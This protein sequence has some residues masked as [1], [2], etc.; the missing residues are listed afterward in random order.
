MPCAA[1]CSPYSARGRFES[2]PCI[3]KVQSAPKRPATGSRKRSVEPLS[4][5][6]SS[7]P[8]GLLL[9][10]RGLTCRT[11]CGPSSE[12]VIFAPSAFRQRTV[13]AIS[14]ERPRYEIATGRSPSAA[15]ISSLCSCDLLEGTCRVPMRTPGCRTTVFCC[16]TT[17]STM[18]VPPRS[19]PED[20]SFRCGRVRSFRCCGAPPGLWRT[21]TTS[22]PT[23]LP[24]PAV[25]PGTL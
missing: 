3:T 10:S 6:S 23:W 16:L 18:P 4:P 1:S 21:A 11:L 8:D 17:L 5:Q 14:S 20:P 7:T 24:P 15:Q 22:C 19:S 2:L 25:A 12:T 9:R 13:A